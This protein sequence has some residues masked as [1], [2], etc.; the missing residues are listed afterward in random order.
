MKRKQRL[1]D[2]ITS[3]LKE[4]SAYA[5][6]HQRN[7]EPYR[8][9]KGLFSVQNDPVKR[10]QVD[11]Y[12][13][14]IQVSLTIL[15]LSNT[16]ARDE[17][18]ANRILQQISVLTV[19]LKSQRAHPQKSSKLAAILDELNQTDSNAFHYF[20]AQEKKTQ[21][22]LLLNNMKENQSRLSLIQVMIEKKKCLMNE[23]LDEKKRIIL[24]NEYDL[25]KEQQNCLV[26]ELEKLRINLE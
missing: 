10:Y 21:K 19:S 24:K 16:L 22:D 6:I 13:S 2:T 12:L 7:I 18:I 14:E 26:S 9:P 11:A 4:L 25:L 5:L 20:C 3:R 1:I 15:K 8:Y 23:T 17:Q